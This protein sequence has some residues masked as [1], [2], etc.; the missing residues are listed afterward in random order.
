MTSYQESIIR[1]AYLDLIGAE[2][3]H[4]ANLHHNWIQHRLTIKE[5]GEAFPEILEV[6]YGQ[7]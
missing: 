3:A 7:D 5:L 4:T 2:E 6:V 1:C